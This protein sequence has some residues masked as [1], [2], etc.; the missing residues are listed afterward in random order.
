MVHDGL[1][2][3][4]RRRAHGRAGLVRRPRARHLA[5]GAGRVGAALARARRGR[6]G[7]GPLRAT[8]SSRSAS[9]DADESAAPRHVARAARGAQAGL[10]PGGHD[11]R[12]QRAGRERRRGRASSSAPR[13]SRSGAASSR[14]P[15][16]SRRATSPTTSPTSRARRRRPGSDGA[17]EGRQDDRRRR[18]RRAERGVLRR[19]R[20]TRRGCSAPTPR[21]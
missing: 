13:S 2:L 15:R 11:D 5:R 14:S 16:S 4:L 9:V 21:P 17:R 6:D 3:E 8:R 19:S 10:R 1:T 12:R 7:R 20:S 18:A